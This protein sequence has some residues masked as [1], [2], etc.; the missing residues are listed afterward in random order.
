ML[1]YKNRTF[2]FQP[3]LTEPE[4]ILMINIICS[5]N[6]DK[7]KCLKCTEFFHQRHFVQLDA[8]QIK[9]Q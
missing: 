3:N 6:Q 1:L 5:V 9:S 2:I 7:R 4:Q 8:A